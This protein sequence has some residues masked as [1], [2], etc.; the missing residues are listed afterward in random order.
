L[1]FVIFAS[2][3]IDDSAGRYKRV[4]LASQIVEFRDQYLE[5]SKPEDKTAFLAARRKWIEDLNIVGDVA[6]LP[7]ALC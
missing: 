2:A 7:H 5:L 1:T 3:H 6:S 4:F